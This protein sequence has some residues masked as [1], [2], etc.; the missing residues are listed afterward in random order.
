MLRQFEASG[1][2]FHGA[3]E[4]A[5]FVSEKLAFHQGF[6]HRGAIDRDERPARRVTEVMDCPRDQF[7]ACTAFP[8]TRHVSLC[9]APPDGSAKT[10]AACRRGAHQVHQHAIICELPLQ[11]FGFFGQTALWER[12]FEQDA[13][14]GRLDR[15]FEEPERAQI[16]NCRDSR[17]DVAERGQNDRRRHVA[18][19][20]KPLQQLEAVHARHHQVCYK[21]LNRAVLTLSSAS[22][23]SDAVSAAKPQDVTMLARPFRCVSSSSTI[24][25][26]AEAAD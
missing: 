21:N 3:G 2:P 20:A 23:P 12:P 16:V 7:F 17:F 14:R 18:H 24:S 6:G 19:A 1:P 15:L 11:A 8:L 26:L 10:P 13:Q 25:T 5:L 4:R 22:W 9:S